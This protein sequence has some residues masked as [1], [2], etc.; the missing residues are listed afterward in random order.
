M[1]GHNII[2]DYKLN[3]ES[4]GLEDIWRQ[5]MQT[6]ILKHSSSK[7]LKQPE[8]TF[9]SSSEGCQIILN[10][11]QSHHQTAQYLSSC[12]CSNGTIIKMS[13]TSLVCLFP[14]RTE[15]PRLIEWEKLRMQVPLSTVTDPVIDHP[16]KENKPLWTPVTICKT[17]KQ[18]PSHHLAK[19]K[20]V[21]DSSVF[22]LSS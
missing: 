2:K 20:C 7:L 21:G 17:R 5:I 4:K 16:E 1:K 10:Y 9:R 14:Q 15:L 19:G 22:Y 18:I 12:S 11:G 6:V 3:W 13:V 8:C